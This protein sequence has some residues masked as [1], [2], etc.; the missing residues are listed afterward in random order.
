MMAEMC[1]DGQLSIHEITYHY[2]FNE[3]L[4]EKKWFLK[5]NSAKKNMIYE[6][7][8]RIGMG[9]DS[10]KNLHGANHNCFEL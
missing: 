8:I 5:R 9:M 6:Y 7:G 2:V 1:N 4:N 10:W 3:M